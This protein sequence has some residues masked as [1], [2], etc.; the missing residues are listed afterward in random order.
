MTSAMASAK[1]EVPYLTVDPAD[2]PAHADPFEITAQMGYLPCRL[3]L[4]RLPAAFDKLSEILD[5]MPIEKLDGQPGLLATFQL[6]PLIDGGAL[7][8]LTGEIDNLVVPGTDKLDMDAVTAAFRDYSFVAS[9]YLLEPCWETYST[10]KSTDKDGNKGYGLGRQTL[11]RCIAGPLVRCGA[12]L[13]IPPFMSYAASYALYNYYLVRPSAGHGDYENLRLVRAFEKGLDPKSSEAG[14]ILTHIHMVVRT[15]ALIEGAVDVLHAAEA[16]SADTAR[17]GLAKI[18]DAMQAIEAAMESMWGNSKPKDYMSYRT[19]IYGITSQSM[20]PD[21][22][23]YEGSFDDKPVAFRGESGANDAII[24]LLDHLCEIPMPK[25]PLTDILVEFREYRPKPHRRFLKYVRETA[26]EVGVR[27]FLTKGAGDL[28]AAIMYLRVLDH[29]RSFRWRHWQFTREYILKYTQH[30]TAT[31]GS[32]IIT[33][34]P[35]QLAAVMD[36][37]VD[38]A[39]G[40][41]LWA[42]LEEGVWT[43]GGAGAGSGSDKEGAGDERWAGL[44]K[45]EIDTV[46]EMMQNVVIQRERLAKEVA[47]YCQ[48]RKAGY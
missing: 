16:E 11:P 6:G 21:G 42:I 32:P 4:R 35:N 31:G 10:G 24:P 22:V 2:V 9:S 38:V 15:G 47:K 14:F 43:G 26:A 39:Q 27:G 29:V 7:P 30:P 25:N 8:D 44:T 18:L 33:W 5:E 20:F 13:D 46:G 36:L 40:S 48:E 1:T 34:L 45:K 12:I 28:S 23:V 17:Q 3:P 19:F 41:G 37:M